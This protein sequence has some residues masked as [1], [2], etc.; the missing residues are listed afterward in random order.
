MNLFIILMILLIIIA[1]SNCDTREDFWAKS[2]QITESNINKYIT[3][4]LQN[5]I[6]GPLII[7]GGLDISGDI[8]GRTISNLQ[9]QINAIKNNANNANITSNIGGPTIQG[10]GINGTISTIANGVRSGIW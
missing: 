1:I 9:A 6:K 8:T 3:K 7:D 4:Y 5:S 2:V 10:G